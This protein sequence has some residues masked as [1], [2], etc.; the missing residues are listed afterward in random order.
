M[1]SCRRLPLIH[2]VLLN[3]LYCAVGV[4][5]LRQAVGVLAYLG[6]IRVHVVL[7]KS[8]N[9]TDRYVT[10]YLN[11]NLLTLWPWAYSIIRM[12]FFSIF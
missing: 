3:R 4:V 12:P 1:V 11:S 7:N 5:A 6:A 8:H 2:G 9:E 10:D